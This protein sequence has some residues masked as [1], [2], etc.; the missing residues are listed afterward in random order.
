VPE[1]LEQEARAA[2]TATE[3][4]IRRNIVTTVR[5]RTPQSTTDTVLCLAA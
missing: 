5:K 2:N 1:E 3:R 4:N